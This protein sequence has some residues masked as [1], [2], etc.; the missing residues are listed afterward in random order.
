LKR[1]IIGQISL[2]LISSELLYNGEI[3][4]KVMK[5]NISGFARECLGLPFGGYFGLPG[6]II[7]I[8]TSSLMKI[9]SSGSF[10]FQFHFTFPTNFHI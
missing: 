5:R 8:H 6:D 2:P 4:A 9:L 3:Y 10:L 7:Q 1:K